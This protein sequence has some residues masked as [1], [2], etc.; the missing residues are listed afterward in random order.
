MASRLRAA[1]VLAVCAT[2][3]WGAGCVTCPPREVAKGKPTPAQQ[4]AEY[5]PPAAEE[6]G[7]GARAAPA[8]PV[9]VAPGPEARAAIPLGP[10]PPGVYRV[11]PGDT[12]WGIAARAYGDPYRW[13]DIFEANRAKISDPDMIYPRLEL[14]IPRLG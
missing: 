5:A 14:Q 2:L 3:A 13:R 10:V 8:P 1:L 7:R 11:R 4:C 9:R 12:L 6:A